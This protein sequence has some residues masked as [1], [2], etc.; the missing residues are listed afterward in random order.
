M[1][2]QAE[3]LEVEVPVVEVVE[4]VA[5]VAVVADQEEVVLVALQLAVLW[6]AAQQSEE[7]VEEA[8]VA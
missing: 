6:E 4:A 1:A 8:M 2:M 3:D 7:V 5:Q